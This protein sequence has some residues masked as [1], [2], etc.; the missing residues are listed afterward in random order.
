MYKNLRCKS[1][2][3]EFLV[4]CVLFFGKGCRPP[5]PSSNKGYRV[6]VIN[7]DR[8]IIGTSNSLRHRSESIGLYGNF[9]VMEH[10][11]GRSQTCLPAPVMGSYHLSGVGQ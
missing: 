5:S 7:S 4:F 1:L 3:V 9:Q 2:H 11:V 6:V 8:A 10:R